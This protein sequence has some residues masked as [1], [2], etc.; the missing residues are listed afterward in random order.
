MAD[1]TIK[2]GGELESMATGKIVAAASAIKDKTRGKTQEAINGDVEAAIAEQSAQFEALSEETSAA[3]ASASQS[4]RDAKQ[5]LADLQEAIKD[6][7]DGQAVTVEVAVHTTAINTLDGKVGNKY[8]VDTLE[9]A[10]PT[11]NFFNFAEGTLYTD[12]IKFY[13]EEIAVASKLQSLIYRSG[14]TEVEQYYNVQAGKTI[15]LENINGERVVLKFPDSACG[16]KA[17]ACTGQYIV[18]TDADKEISDVKGSIEETNAEIENRSKG[19]QTNI[20]ALD[21]MLN[22]STFE[23]DYTG[24]TYY[25]PYKDYNFIKGMSYTLSVSRSV[26]NNDRI[27]IILYKGG[28]FKKTYEIYNNTLTWT[29]EDDCDQFRLAYLDSSS[30]TKCIYTVKLT[31]ADSIINDD[32]MRLARINSNLDK[33]EVRA[34]TY[35]DSVDVVKETTIA[36]TPDTTLY[37]ATTGSDNNDGTSASPLKTLQ[38]AID[39]AISGESNNV[40]IVLADGEYYSEDTI[41]ISNSDKNIRIKSANARQATILHAEKVTPSQS[42][43][44]VT[45]ETDYEVFS[46]KVDDDIILRSQSHDVNDP[47]TLY[48]TYGVQKVTENGTTYARIYTDEESAYNAVS[49]GDTISVYHGWFATKLRVT[50]K[51]TDN[52]HYVLVSTDPILSNLTHDIKPYGTGYFCVQNHASDNTGDFVCVPH[53]NGYLVTFNYSGDITEH[54]VYA[55]TEG[56]TILVSGSSNVIFDGLSFRLNSPSMY[57]GCGIMVNGNNKNIQARNDAEYAAIDI[58]NSSGISILNCDFAKVWDY[59]VNISRSNN[60]KVWLNKFVGIYGGAVQ[61]WDAENTIRTSYKMNH[62]ILIYNN[63]IKDYGLQLEDAVGLLIQGAD[64]YYISHNTIKNGHYSAISLGWT[65]QY[66]DSTLGVGYVGYNEVAFTMNC[67]LDDGGGIYTVSP[68]TGC[69]IELNKIHDIVGAGRSTLVRGIYHD[70]GSNRYIDRQNTIYA[71]QALIRAKVQSR[72]YSNILAYPYVAVLEI[73][74]SIMDYSMTA[75]NN[76]ILAEKELVRSNAK[77]NDND[78]YCY[79]AGNLIKDITNE[80]TG[81][82]ILHNIYYQ[83]EIFEDSVNGD[84]TIPQANANTIRGVTGFIAHYGDGTLSH[85]QYKPMRDAQYGVLATAWTYNMQDIDSAILEKIYYNYSIKGSLQGL[86]YWENLKE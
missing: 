28:Q 16:I 15:E 46:V 53:N 42:G 3:V 25:A 83:G 70:T 27:V 5:Y 69:L 59:A 34:E 31:N 56:S 84:F 73:Y 78:K 17:I 7:P 57:Y 22:S 26:A 86:E 9:D 12:K 74:P 23:I 29:N 54:D 49:V 62:D 55:A 6:L 1:N 4:A 8:E 85:L 67:L 81:D 13:I 68:T 80:T 21:Q 30:Y 37:V 10:S 60:V 38:A 43:N 75:T 44:V 47:S 64:K 41:T 14:S 50:A 39:M 61:V 52:G 66:S 24:D 72:V 65:W 19:L 51:T 2:I 18:N 48:N 11:I 79:M 33:A 40:D 76:V 77:A 20:D 32:A 45:F 71:C 82:D 58:R 63:L 36:F 35:K